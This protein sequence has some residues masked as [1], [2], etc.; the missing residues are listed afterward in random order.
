MA[1]SSKAAVI[2]ATILALLLCASAAP[3]PTLSLADAAAR[4]P[5]DFTPL[6]ADRLVVVTG[7]VPKA[8]AR[9]PGFPHLAIQARGPA[10]GLVG[11]GAL[12]PHRPPGDRGQLPGGAAL[13][14]R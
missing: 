14:A 10:L 4:K 2:R 7:P 1:A 12:S 3:E 13:P 11:C 6:Y 5:P 9:L 8:L